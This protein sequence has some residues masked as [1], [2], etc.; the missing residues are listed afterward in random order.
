MPDPLIAVTC[1]Y[2]D[3]GDSPWSAIQLTPQLYLDA[4]QMAGGIPLLIPC[5][6][7]SAAIERLMQTADGLLVTGGPDFDPRE[8]G[9]QPRAKFGA[10]SPE[11]DQLD[12][13]AVRFAL[14]RPD[15]PILGICRG[16]QSI[17][18]IAG[19]TLIQDIPSEVE[20]PLKH[21][22]S[23]AMYYG[24]H[25][26][27]VEESRLREIVGGERISVNT[28]HHQAVLEPAPGWRVVARAD[29]GVVEAI[30]RQEGGFGLGCQF[31]PEVMIRHDE[32]MAAIFRAFVGA[33]RG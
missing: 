10:V 11:R 16:I 19:G 5:L 9:Q 26:I 8:Y 13:V 33:C 20:N 25:D 12:R 28:S 24:T 1:S 21:S 7:E 3:S 14:E 15:M 2:R 23:G 27:S 32:R 22:Q 29:D 4:I 18:V 6:E 31:H 17:N 30:E